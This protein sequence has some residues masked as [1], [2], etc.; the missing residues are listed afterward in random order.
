MRRSCHDG[1]AICKPMGPAPSRAG[2]MLPQLEAFSPNPRDNA[3]DIT[4]R[5]G[6][7]VG[8]TGKP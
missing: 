3:P 8:W 2:G 4:A 1:T 6:P 5:Y 7:K